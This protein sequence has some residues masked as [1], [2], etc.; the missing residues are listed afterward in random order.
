M[1][2][3]PGNYQEKLFDFH[4]DILLKTVHGG[5]SD[6]VLDDDETCSKSNDGSWVKLKR[7]S[8]TKPSPMF[9][10]LY[11]QANIEGR[12]ATIITCTPGGLISQQKLCR[13]MSQYCISSSWWMD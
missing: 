1:I 3:D 9:G 7:R 5:W 13:T 4:D 10:G 8:C 6:W 12:K 11:C 2:C